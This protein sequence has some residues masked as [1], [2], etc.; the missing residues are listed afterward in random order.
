MANTSPTGGSCGT[1]LNGPA[2]FDACKTILERLEPYKKTDPK[3]SWKTW[4]T[5]ALTDRVSLNVIGHYDKSPL[6][7]DSEKQTGDFFVYF[8]YGVGVVQAEV[9]CQTGQDR[10][11]RK[12]S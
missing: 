9:N 5:A 10:E 1:D 4:V 7:Y 6:D 3:G 2:V 11:L 12:S 8:T